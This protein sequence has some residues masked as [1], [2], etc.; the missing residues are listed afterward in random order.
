MLPKE[1]RLK[2]KKDFEKVIKQGRG[3]AGDFL[4]LKFL[5]T[6][7]ETSRVGFVVSKKVSAKAVVR[8]KIKRRLREAVKIYL[9]K[10]TTSHDMIFFSK[11][12]IA[13]QDKDFQEITKAVNALLG[14]AGLLN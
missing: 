3:V 9:P 12:K 1:N 8:N 11:H 4:S 2:K 7:A 13:E 6:G 5:F 10:L 14:R